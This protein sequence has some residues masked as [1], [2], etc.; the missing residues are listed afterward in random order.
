MEKLAHTNNEVNKQLSVASQLQK[1]EVPVFIGDPLQY[2]FWYR[3]FAALV[4]S[5][6]LGPQ[7]KLNLIN[8]YVAGEQKQV[9]EHY[10]LI[11]TSDVY[12]IAKSLLHKR[13]GNSS[14]VSTSFLKKLES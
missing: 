6:E 8:Q 11:G 9:A 4:D 13:Y 2:L 7:I 3:L 10:L 5:Q 14:V 1:I 12:D